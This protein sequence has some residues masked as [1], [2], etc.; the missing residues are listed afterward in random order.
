M[1]VVTHLDKL[2]NEEM[3]ATATTKSEFVEPF[4]VLILGLDLLLDESNTTSISESTDDDV[5]YYASTDDQDGLY[6]N[7]EEEDSLVLARDRIHFN[8]NGCEEETKKTTKIP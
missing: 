6:D 8:R 1:T 7:D 4:L 5:S 3:H 2:V